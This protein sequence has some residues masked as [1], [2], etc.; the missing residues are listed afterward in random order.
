MM[1]RRSAQCLNHILVADLEELSELL[2]CR[3]APRLRPQ[4]LLSLFHLERELLDA[5]RD[6]HEPTCVA[7]VAFELTENRRDGE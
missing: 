6:V 5:T 7:E 3:R 2:C 1:R 4:M